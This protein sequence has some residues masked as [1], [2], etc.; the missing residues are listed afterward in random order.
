MLRAH[1]G[2]RD[3]EVLD[4]KAGR[5]K[6]PASR[7]RRSPDQARQHGSNA[8]RHR[9]GETRVPRSLSPKL[10]GTV[11]CDC[12]TTLAVPNRGAGVVNHIPGPATESSIAPERSRRYRRVSWQTTEIGWDPSRGGR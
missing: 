11:P 4:R 10:V 6:A 3:V 9:T 12:R 7:S 8:R 1:S 5:E 2:R